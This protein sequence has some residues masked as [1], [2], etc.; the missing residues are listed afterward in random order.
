[1]LA[2]KISVPLARRQS[3]RNSS[4]SGS[5]SLGGGTLLASFLFLLDLL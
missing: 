1:L 4:E 5:S 2:G 3:L